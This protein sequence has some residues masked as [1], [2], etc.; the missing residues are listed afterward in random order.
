MIS[1]FDVLIDCS[2][3]SMFNILL[4]CPFGDHLALLFSA[5]NNCLLDLR[6]YIFLVLV[7]KSWYALL[8]NG[9][10]SNFDWLYRGVCSIL[11]CFCTHSLILL[12]SLIIFCCKQLLFWGFYNFLVLIL[13][14]DCLEFFMFNIL[15]L[16]YSFND[17][18]M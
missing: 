4:L 11:W 10:V 7:L 2:R 12:C 14:L 15:M 1:T 16:L 3:F 18:I 13:K 6:F 9:V 17:F 5:V 8:Y